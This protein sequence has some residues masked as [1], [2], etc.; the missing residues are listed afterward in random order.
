MKTL[1]AIMTGLA[2]L[3][4]CGFASAKTITLNNPTKDEAVD[5]YTNAV[6]HGDLSGIENAID[7]DA[8]FNMTRAGH[9]TILTKDELINY[10][11][12]GADFQQ[13]C[14]CTGSVV[15]DTD[16]KYIKKVTM[17]FGGYIRT[18]VVTAERAG[19]GWKVT[20]VETSFN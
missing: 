1:K 5:T 18:D 17:D 15:Q 19:N 13:K 20:K 2:L 3:M 7:D 12:S 14:K 10:L 9:T 4:V 11:K 16:D 6:V 8:Q